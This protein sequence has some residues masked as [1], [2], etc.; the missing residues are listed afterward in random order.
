MEPSIEIAELPSKQWKHPW[1]Q[2]KLPASSCNSFHWLP[3]TSIDFRL[4]PQSLHMLASGTMS[5]RPYR[6]GGGRAAHSLVN[7]PSTYQLWSPSQA[8]GDSEKY[9]PSSKR[10]LV[11]SFGIPQLVKFHQVLITTPSLT[12]GSQRNKTQE[13][14]YHVLLI[15]PGLNFLFQDLIWH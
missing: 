10:E 11:L 12:T 1:I 14:K 6:R 2:R 5:F 13:A 7:M 8:V 3:P 4:L 9:N 15:R